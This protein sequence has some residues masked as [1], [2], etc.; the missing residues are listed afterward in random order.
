M[1]LA[2]RIAATAIATL[3]FGVST[4]LASEWWVS[5][6][7]SASG[8]TAGAGWLSWSRGT[9]GR[10]GRWYERVLWHD[11]VESLFD[12]PDRMSVGTDRLGRPVAVFVRCLDDNFDYPRDCAVYERAI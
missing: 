9:G 8:I 11:G 3:A 10:D 2:I 12:V 5:T 4:A 7:P 1:R 6:E